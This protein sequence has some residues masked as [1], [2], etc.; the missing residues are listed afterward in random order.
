YTFG[1]YDYGT[2]H[3]W[4]VLNTAGQHSITVRDTANPALTASQAGI[5]VN[6]V[7]TVTGPQAG[8]RNQTLTFTLGATSGLP[9]GTV[10]TYTIDWNGDGIVDQ[11]ISGPSGT[12]VTHSYADAG[13]YSVG[14]TATVHLGA[15]DYTSY[16]TYQSVAIF[17]VTATVQ[18]DPGDATKSALVVQG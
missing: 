12:T 11:T 7:A 9:P 4:A 8:L 1:A 16:T 15:E 17:A 13:W 6:P 14:V 2:G 5:H 18:A 10:F 3:F